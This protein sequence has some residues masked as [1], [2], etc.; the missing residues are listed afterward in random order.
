MFVGPGSYAEEPTAFEACTYFATRHLTIEAEMRAVSLIGMVDFGG[1]Y[2]VQES[3]LQ[4]YTTYLVRDISGELATDRSDGQ[5]IPTGRF[6]ADF[7]CLVDVV[8]RRVLTVSLQDG[9]SVG[10]EVELS[11]GTKRQLSG[12]KETSVDIGSMSHQGKY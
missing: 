3:A 10:Q 2:Q 6:S 12:I 4:R 8:D 5:V 9:S 1:E 7:L 11:N